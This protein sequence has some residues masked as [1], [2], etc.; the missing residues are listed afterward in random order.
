MKCGMCKKRSKTWNGDDP[1]C[2]FENGV[3][4]PNNWNCA[5]MN[6]LRN[7]AEE[8][9]M[10]HRYDLTVGSFGTVPWE[11]NRSKGIVFMTW[12]KERGKTSNAIVM[13]DDEPVRKLTL[14]DAEDAI[15]YYREV[16][17]G[18]RC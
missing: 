13:Y 14:K 10:S 16:T 15:T 17:G 12:Y 11:C 8:I 2:A 7:I 18:K 3:F 1:K 4:S 6:E 9:E 5:T